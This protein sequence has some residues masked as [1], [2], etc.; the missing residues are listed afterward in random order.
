MHH[1]PSVCRGCGEKKLLPILA[2][3]NLPAS[4]GPDELVL[5]P[6]CKLVQTPVIAPWQLHFAEPSHA[7]RT[8]HAWHVRQLAGQVV[9]TQKLK[10]TSFVIEIGSRDGCLLEYYQAAG[11]PVLGIDAE[12]GMA[13]LARRKRG[14]PTLSKRFDRQLAEQ[15]VGCSEPADVVHAHGVLSQAT[16]LNALVS[17]LP[18]VLK[19]TGVA[20]IEVPYVRDLVE[21]VDI[22]AVDNHCVSYFSLTS[23]SNLL[24]RHALVVHDAERVAVHPGTLRVFAGRQG[25]TSGR[26]SKLIA[27]EA[28]AGIARPNYYV[29]LAEH[30]AGA[31]HAKVA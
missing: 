1:A 28:S 3:G 15:L 31:H 26:A 30:V 9:A 24:S 10:P 4:P 27:D 14:V 8:S 12:P 29:S 25:F 17:G 20:V 13:E 6:Q 23:L 22:R 5:C 16:D 2:L 11:I 19:D 7:V 21:R 18:L